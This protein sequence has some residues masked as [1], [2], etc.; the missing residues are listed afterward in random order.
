MPKPL[1]GGLCQGPKPEN[2]WFPI[3]FAIPTK[4]ENHPGGRGQ[5]LTSMRQAK[6]YGRGCTLPGGGLPKSHFWPVTFWDHFSTQHSQNAKITLFCAQFERCTFFEYTQCVPNFEIC[7][8]KPPFDHF[9]CTTYGQ[10]KHKKITL[11][12]ARGDPAKNPVTN[13]GGKKPISHPGADRC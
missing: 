10:K 13:S 2:H 1:G 12:K 5:R 6:T 11:K 8:T 3:F 9:F 7:I 4:R